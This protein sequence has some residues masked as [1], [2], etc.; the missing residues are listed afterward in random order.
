[1]TNKN[2]KIKAFNFPCDVP[3]TSWWSIS[4][5]PNFR[6]VK[7][8]GYQNLKVGVVKCTNSSGQIN[9]SARSLGTDNVNFAFLGAW[10]FKKEIFKKEKK[11]IKNGGKFIVHVPSPKIINK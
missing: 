3:D 11:F 4:L 7:S 9:N 6:T 2:R 5:I 10:N 8:L 1:M